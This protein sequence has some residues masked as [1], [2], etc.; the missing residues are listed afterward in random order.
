MS[1]AYRWMAVV[2]ILW[3][4]YKFLQ[5]GG[6][7]VL[8]GALAVLVIAGMLAMPLVRFAASLSSPLFRQQLS[9]GQLARSS[10][11][12]GALGAAVLLTPLPFRV[13]AP[14]MVAAARGTRCLRRRAWQTGPVGGAR[15][16]C[17]G[18][19][20]TSAAGE[21]GDRQGN[22]R[23]DGPAATSNVCGCGI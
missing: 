20:G 9:V 21:S 15:T 8:A 18:R 2:A 11:V 19:R 12:W 14:V 23:V 13:S 3:G 7:Q 10:V 16:A 4:C 1:L 5:P 22:R 17:D 6:L